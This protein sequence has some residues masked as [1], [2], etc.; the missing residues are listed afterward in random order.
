M[1]PTLTVAQVLEEVNAGIPDTALQR[2]LDAASRLVQDYAEDA[3][4]VLQNEAV[5]RVLGWL[6]DQ[7]HA[8]LRSDRVGEWERQYAAGMNNALVHSGASALLARYSERRL[9]VL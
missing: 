3:P 4:V 9:G 2:H 8:S 1:A 7:P 5:L 6:L